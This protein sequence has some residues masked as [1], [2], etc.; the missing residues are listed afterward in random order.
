MEKESKLKGKEEEKGKKVLQKQE[1]TTVG[2]ND[3][4]RHGLFEKIELK[5]FCVCVKIEQKRFCVFFSKI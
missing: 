5:N 4:N 2:T 1:R 3:S